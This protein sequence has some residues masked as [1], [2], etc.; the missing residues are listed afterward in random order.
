LTPRRE[1]GNDSSRKMLSVAGG[2]GL[3]RD[4]SGS[5]NQ[6]GKSM[7]DPIDVKSMI[8]PDKK[9]GRSNTID[10]GAKIAPKT[11]ISTSKLLFQKFSAHK[12]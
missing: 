5:R 2:S 1:L 9:S 6:L 4:I 7:E 3:S 10:M 11:S 12:S 8:S